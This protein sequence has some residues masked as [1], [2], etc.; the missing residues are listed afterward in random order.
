[1]S[2]VLAFRPRHSL[3]ELRLLKSLDDANSEFEGCNT[4]SVKKTENVCV[5]GV[6][7]AMAR[8]EFA[9]VTIRFMHSLRKSQ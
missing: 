5:T 1:M 7:S 9:L 4:R 2:K 6:D 3:K 8:Q